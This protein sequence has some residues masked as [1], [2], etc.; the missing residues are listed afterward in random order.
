MAPTKP[1][2]QC[3]IHGFA[4]LMKPLDINAYISG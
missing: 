1:N 3:R 2:S 4:Q